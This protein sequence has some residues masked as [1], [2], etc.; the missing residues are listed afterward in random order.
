MTRALLVLS[1]AMLVFGL[2][3][4]AAP[5]QPVDVALVL[6]IDCS[7]SVVG[8]EFEAQIVGLAE[9]LRSADVAEAIA[10]GPRQRVAVAVVQ[11]AGDRVQVTAVP[12]TI[13]DG[14]DSALRV[15]G[16]I[17]RLDRRT[18]SGETS[19]SGAIRHGL[20]LLRQNPFPAARQVIDI[21]GDGINS[22]GD[23]PEAIRDFAVSQGVV[24]N[25]LAIRSDFH[26]LDLYFEN[27]IIGGPG[28]FVVDATDYLSYRAAIL[29]KLVREITKPSA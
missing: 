11:W 21:S 8:W 13:V 1:M 19:I 12:W 3:A 5:A 20:A 23:Q 18:A 26:D 29:R 28:S 9:A 15:A 10:S 17:A 2:A 22:D 7:D 24:I 14:P 27:W 16:A 6:A 25:G 4:R